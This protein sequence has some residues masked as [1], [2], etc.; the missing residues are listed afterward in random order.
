MKG[1]K[2]DVDFLSSFILN[3]ASSNK[4]SSEEILKEANY[5]ISIIDLKIKEVDNL[6]KTRCKLVDVVSTFNERLDRS[7]EAKNL[8]FYKLENKNLC[9]IICSLLKDKQFS[10]EELQ[11]TLVNKWYIKNIVFCIKQLMEFGIIVKIGDNYLKGP[12]FESY[13][14]FLEKP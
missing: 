3:C 2:I 10:K 8:I 9:N 13:M 5:Q 6:K 12:E 11:K 4:N 14:N 1:K 7:L